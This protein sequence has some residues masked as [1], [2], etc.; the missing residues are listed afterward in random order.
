[1]STAAVSIAVDSAER[2]REYLRDL[3]RQLALVIESAAS[4][5][6]L[7]GRAHKIVSQAGMLELTRMSQCAKALED[8]CRSGAGQAAALGECRAAA[9]D[10]ERFALP[11][12]TPWPAVRAVND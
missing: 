5:E 7:A 10:I 6:S 3:D 2:L 11:A 1:M 8:A 12:A 4:D 9:G